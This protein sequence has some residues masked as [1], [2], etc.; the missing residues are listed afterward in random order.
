[1]RKFLL[2]AAATY[3][4][5]AVTIFLCYKGIVFPASIAAAIFFYSVHQY[6]IELS[7]ARL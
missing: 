2:W 6:N 3:I 5:F 1:M 7:K 4:M